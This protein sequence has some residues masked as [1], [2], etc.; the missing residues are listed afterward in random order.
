MGLK[1]G[2]FGIFS[3][4][5]VEH[6]T[7]KDWCGGV[8]DGRRASQLARTESEKSWKNEFY[9]SFLELKIGIFGIFSSDNV[10]HPINWSRFGAGPLLF[11]LEVAAAR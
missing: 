7:L 9:K 10:S 5:D 3:S 11:D 2:I 1:I 6:P 4:G 8:R